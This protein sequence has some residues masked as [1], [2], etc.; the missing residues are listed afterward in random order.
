MGGL[1]KRNG[2][3]ES[4]PGR[5]QIRRLLTRVPAVLQLILIRAF[6][7]VTPRSSVEWDP[8]IVKMHMGRLESAGDRYDNEDRRHIRQ[9]SPGFLTRLSSVGLL[10]GFRQLGLWSLERSETTSITP[11]SN[12]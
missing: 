2:P 3:I 7:V 10:Y 8:R 5:R 6:G 11:D 1:G 12:G 9:H 4:G